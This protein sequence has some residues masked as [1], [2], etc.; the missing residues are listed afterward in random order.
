[1]TTQ[2]LVRAV[3]HRADV[4]RY[5]A[6]TS[7]LTELR[8]RVVL[9]GTA[10]VDADR[11]TAAQFGL[12]TAQRETVDGYVNRA[13]VAELVERYFLIE[14][15][16]GNVTLRITDDLSDGGTVADTVTV[17]LDLTESLDARERAAGLRVLSEQLAALR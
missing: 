4:V 7:F 2:E 14:D 1:M 17:A 6:S 16:R 8:D 9:T 15:E 5:R 13:A 11:A 12:G 10:A 3:R